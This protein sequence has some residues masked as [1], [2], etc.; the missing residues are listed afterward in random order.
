[1]RSS[2]MYNSGGQ[3]SDRFLQGLVPGSD[4]VGPSGTKI[5]PVFAAAA[6]AA[7]NATLAAPSV[8]SSNMYSTNSATVAAVAAAAMNAAAIAAALGGASNQS[9]GSSGSNFQIP[10][11]SSQSQLKS[12]SRSPPYERRGGGYRNDRPRER[13]SPNY[14]NEPPRR[15]SGSLVGGHPS[16]EDDPT[17]T[18]TLFVGN[19]PPDIRASE[20]RQIFDVYGILEDVEIK[21]PQSSNSDPAYAFLKYVNVSMAY[22]AKLGMTGKRIAGYVCKIGYGKVTPTRCLWVGGLGPWTNYPMFAS[23]VGR[24]SRPKKIV[25]PSGKGYANILYHSIE[26]AAAAANALRGYPLGTGNHRLRVD[27]TDESHMLISGTIDNLRRGRTGASDRGHRQC[28]DSNRHQR[29]MSRS[30]VRPPSR[31]S[32]SSS[33]TSSAAKSATPCPSTGSHSRTRSPSPTVPVPE[34]ISLDT[35]CS[36]EEVATCLAGP[37]W[38]AVFVLKKS[39][40]SCRLHAVSGDS[41]LA[42]RLFPRQRPKP[43]Q[44]PPDD[45]DDNTNNG[46]SKAADIEKR[47][48]VSSENNMNSR[49]EEP[50]LLRISQRMKMDPAKLDDVRKRMKSVGSS[51]YCVLLATE[52]ANEVVPTSASASGDGV[53]NHSRPLR[54]LINYLASKEAAGVV[55]MN[56]ETGRKEHGTG[57]QQKSD[58][59]PSG[60]LHVLPPGDFAVSLLVEGGAS[61]L[62][63]KRVE[64]GDKYLVIL[65][66]KNYDVL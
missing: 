59:E 30:P 12:S 26:A 25:W 64:P 17:A 15:S 58:S 14:R 4:L 47:Q 31:R 16:P 7:L 49:A 41:T 54:D 60:V 50:P 56:N 32:P 34:D 21:R 38:K 63:E 45:E 13:D 9:D 36:I 66:L 23:L 18:R 24:F 57:E 22:R 5:D 42:D 39:N 3:H 20:L 35:A 37:I 44:T 10:G 33:V 8:S 55:L 48:A 19:L 46:L 40:F 51:G 6:A 62:Q 61:C 65:V 52:A 11:M 53:E 28:R 29:S 27:F 2:D 1:M 43:P